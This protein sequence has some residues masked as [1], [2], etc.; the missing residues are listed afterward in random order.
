MA[1]NPG[2]FPIEGGEV[3]K[4]RSLAFQ[5]MGG[6]SEADEI[7]SKRASRQ[8]EQSENNVEARRTLYSYAYP[9]AYLPRRYRR[10]RGDHL[11]PIED[12][13]TDIERRLSAMAYANGLSKDASGI[14]IGC[15]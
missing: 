12:K 10:R 5:A 14:D 13:V 7:A 9:S 8:Y 4:R 2:E 11:A 1:R 15:G 3:A 6:L